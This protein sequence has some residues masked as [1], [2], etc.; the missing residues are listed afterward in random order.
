V[1]R[2]N[3]P[4]RVN[5]VLFSPVHG[6]L[7]AKLLSE[8]VIADRLDERV[9]LQMHKNIWSPETRGVLREANCRCI[10][11]WRARFLY[12]RSSRQA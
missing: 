4:V 1:L 2:E 12:S 5:A 8:W 10:A 6:T 7:D 9:Q 11:Q 3:L